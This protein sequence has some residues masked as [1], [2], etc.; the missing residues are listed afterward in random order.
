MSPFPLTED[1]LSESGS[2]EEDTIG[3]QKRPRSPTDSSYYEEENTP[4]RGQKR[5][6]PCP[7]TSHNQEQSNSH[8]TDEV[9]E[10]VTPTGECQQGTSGG[11]PEPSPRNKPA[12][13]TYAGAVK[14]SRPQKHMN[15]AA[16]RQQRPVPAPKPK[17]AE[18]PVII[19]PTDGPVSFSKLGSWRQA[20]LLKNV[21]G[22]VHSIQQIAN[23]EWLIGC[24]S[25]QQQRKLLL[26]TTL[27]VQPSNPVC[28]NTR[29]PLNVVVGVIKGVPKEPN[30]EQLL[31]DDLE[32]QDLH[33]DSV[34]RLNTKDGAPTGAVRVAFIRNQL[35]TTVKL[36]YSLHRVAPYI[37]PIRRCTKCQTLGHS[38]QE[39]RRKHARCARCGKGHPTTEC[40]SKTL[41]CVNCCGPHSASDHRCPEWGIRK[42]AHELK[43]TSF[44]P[45]S[46]AITL[47]R[48]R[49]TTKEPS[50]ERDFA[51][52]PQRP[53]Q[54]PKTTSPEP[55]P[56]P[57]D[58]TKATSTPA[59]KSSPGKKPPNQDA[60]NNKPV[61]TV[62]TNK[63]AVPTTKKRAVASTTTTGTDPVSRSGGKEST[64]PTIPTVKEK[65]T[66]ALSKDSITMIW[67]TI[68]AF[69]S[70]L[71]ETSPQAAQILEGV[72]VIL[73][74]VIDIAK[75]GC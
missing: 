46:E 68:M 63:A 42:L 75:G 50:Q 32:A 51:V 60:H 71:A 52:R 13:T 9:P 26:Q 23:G 72:F 19:K 55:Q 7:D 31:R 66:R 25:A 27:P 1:S 8:N 39:C 47:A 11:S 10:A 73:Q 57:A 45:F 56:T 61:K 29:I 21:V 16:P 70:Q 14:T 58:G 33:V 41:F 49:W 54:T 74:T 24:T 30:A 12:S 59:A 62:P 44:L 34:K 4:V 38:K 17:L 20:Q 64:H 48:S 15:A 40:D 53:P 37:P 67:E 65:T 28:I 2:E 18:Y 36:G 3:G 43:N 69:Q 22:A 35:P 5:P 6:C